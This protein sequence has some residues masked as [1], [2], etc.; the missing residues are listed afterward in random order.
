MRRAAKRDTNERRIVEALRMVPGVTV[1][2]IS[3]AGVPDLLVGFRDQSFLLEVKAAK[4]KLTDPEQAF[5]DT[6]TGHAVIVRCLDDA[7]K[8]I[9]V[10]D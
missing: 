6:W 3:A 4:G 2:Q 5:F 1:V 9:G 10:T 7:L 8:A